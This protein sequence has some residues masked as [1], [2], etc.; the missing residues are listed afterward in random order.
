MKYAYHVQGPRG[1]GE[2]DRSDP[3]FMSFFLAV[4]VASLL[5]AMLCFSVALVAF[6]V[7]GRS[8]AEAI[9][10]VTIASAGLIVSGLCAL[11]LSTD[12]RVEDCIRP[13]SPDIRR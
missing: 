1:Q 13:L 7:Q 5:W 8:R 4:P 11:V 2:R 9:V 12:E 3:M 6:C 10:L